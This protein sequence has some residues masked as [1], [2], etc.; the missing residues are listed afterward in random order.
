LHRC[1]QEAAAATIRLRH[2]HARVAHVEAVLQADSAALNRLKG[3]G[4]PDQVT[5]EV[6]DDAVA[7]GKRA[8]E[9]ATRGVARSTDMLRPLLTRLSKAIVELERDAEDL[10]TKLSPIAGGAFDVL[11][12][13]KT[14]PLVCSLDGGACGECHL[15]L[16]TAIAGSV[17]AR[18]TVLRCPHCRRVL[19][20]R[21][22]DASDGSSASR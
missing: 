10:R 22:S 20:A 5:V 4:E 19:V 15:F 12:R 3:A 13:K 9:S 18:Q 8:Y 7:G 21:A 1:R 11:M 6:L 17:A 16:P 14:L 2:E